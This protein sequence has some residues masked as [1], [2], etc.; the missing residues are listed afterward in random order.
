MTVSGDSDVVKIQLA[1]LRLKTFGVGN[2]RGRGEAVRVGSNQ[3]KKV[4]VASLE[5][6]RDKFHTNTGGWKTWHAR[7]S[8]VR[9]GT[10]T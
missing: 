4:T 1:T 8:V 9:R 2:L 5:R 3:H 6:D 10:S 7:P